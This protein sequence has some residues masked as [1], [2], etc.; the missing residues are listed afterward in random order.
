MKVY[1]SEVLNKGFNLGRKNDLEKTDETINRLIS[2]GWTLEHVVSPRCRRSNSRNI[3]QRKGRR[4]RRIKMLRTVEKAA[5][6]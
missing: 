4:K 5:I 2:E 1:K 6:N 3:Q